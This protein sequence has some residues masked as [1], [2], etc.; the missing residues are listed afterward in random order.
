MKYQHMKRFVAILLAGMLAALTSACVTETSTAA[1]PEPGPMLLTSGFKAKK[2]TTSAQIEQIR[3]MPEGGFTV[4]KQGRETYYLYPDKRAQKLY[5]GNQYA[6]QEYRR[7]VKMQRARE[8]GAVVIDVNPSRGAP[9][10]EIWHG[11]T[12][13]PEW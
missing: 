11:W 5:A 3:N 10:V 2:A 4:V 8:Q 12:P 7:Q 6:F 1:A 13:F 9:V